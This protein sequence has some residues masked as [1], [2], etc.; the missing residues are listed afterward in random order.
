VHSAPSPP[1]A[2][3]FASDFET[4]PVSL[5]FDDAPHPGMTVDLAP[6]A[7]VEHGRTTGFRIGVES[8]GDDVAR[9]CPDP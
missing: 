9:R 1:S 5:D 2:T 3:S 7:T 4:N 6:D 8:S